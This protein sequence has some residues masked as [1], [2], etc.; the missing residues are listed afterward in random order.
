MTLREFYEKIG[1]SI[2]P[3]LSLMGGSE[4]IVGKF[5]RKFPN[6]P[7]AA[8]LF[9]TFESKDFQTAFRMAHTLKGV[10]L[11]LGFDKLRESAAEL[12][13]ALR[14]TVA[15]NAPELLEEVR[16]NY[17]EVISAINEIDA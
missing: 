9:R 8:E 16:R 13:E 4:R 14:D 11:N 10:C 12:T 7:S 1:S 17:D 5:V 6:D 2:D 15:D 3:V